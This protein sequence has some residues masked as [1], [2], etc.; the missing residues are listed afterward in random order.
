M[1]LRAKGTRSLF[2]DASHHPGKFF[3]ETRENFSGLLK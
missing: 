3:R 1:S 2:H